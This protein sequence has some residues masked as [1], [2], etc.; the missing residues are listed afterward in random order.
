[1]GKVIITNADIFNHM[2]QYDE[3]QRKYWIQRV[4][5]IGSESA[6]DG[7]AGL[8][9]LEADEDVNIEVRGVPQPAQTSTVA[10]PDRS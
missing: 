4:G 6:G 2:G 7:G 8:G 3:D 5:G 9:C 1:V 10:T